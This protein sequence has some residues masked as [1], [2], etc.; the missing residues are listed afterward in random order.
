MDAK[1]FAVELRT[2]LGDWFRVVQLIQSGSSGDDKQ[3]S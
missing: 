1:D 3:L 2:R